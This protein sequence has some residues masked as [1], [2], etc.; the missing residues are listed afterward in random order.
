MPGHR[1]GGRGEPRKGCQN[2]IK[3]KRRVASG[4]AEQYA[5]GVTDR[6]KSGRMLWKRGGEGMRE[7]VGGRDAATQN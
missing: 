5:A 7:E 2:K 1:C 3:Y 4:D 6:P